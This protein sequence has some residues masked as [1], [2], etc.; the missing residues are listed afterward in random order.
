MENI[1]ESS[2]ADLENNLTVCEETINGD[3]LDESPNG[4]LNK[5]AKSGCFG[6][7]PN[8]VY[9]NGSQSDEPEINFNSAQDKRRRLMRNDREVDFDSSDPVM[10]LPYLDLNRTPI[11]SQI[12]LPDIKVDSPS[13]S[14][15]I[16]NTVEVGNILGF[17]ID[18]DNP[19]LKEVLGENES[20]LGES[21]PPLNITE[22]W[23]DNNWGFEQVF[24]IGRSCGLVSIWDKGAFTLIE[25]FKSIY[26]ILTLGNLV[27]ING[28]TGIINIYGPQSIHEKSKLWDKL[29]SLKSSISATW[30][31]M[32]DFTVVRRQEERIYSVFCSDSASAFNQFIYRG[33]LT[34]LNM[35]GQRFTFVQTQGAKL[36]KLDRILVC[37]IVSQPRFPL[38]H[39]RH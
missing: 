5:L 1:N 30:I 10:P 3:G 29:L 13:S 35:G 26:F 32:G 2:H 21:S 36:S 38:R 19:I 12:P 22:C 25:T 15:E 4:L 9:G 11:P 39:V 24:T 33:E 7:F 37:K 6:P 17:E 18:G 34:D 14:S 20:K 27:G 31:L 28:L 8:N 16:R 23:G